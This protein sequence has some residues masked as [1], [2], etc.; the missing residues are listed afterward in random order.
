MKVKTHSCC[1]T[2]FKAVSRHRITSPMDG[3]FSTC[4]SSLNSSSSWCSKGLWSSMTVAR[5]SS[6]VNT[7]W[8]QHHTG[9]I[10]ERYPG[11]Y[12]QILKIIESTQPV[13]I[14]IH[15]CWWLFGCSGSNLKKLISSFARVVT[16]TEA[17]ASAVVCTTSHK[18][19]S[20]YNWTIFSLSCPV[21]TMRSNAFL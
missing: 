20:L 13:L 17:Q 1:S 19:I 7:W 6:S 16:L 10:L 3:L 15:H 21:R 8:H 12:L 14:Q 18:L 2:H 4:F 9:A 11:H 5:I